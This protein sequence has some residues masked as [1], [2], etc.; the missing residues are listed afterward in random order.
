MPRTVSVTRNRSR[1]G[2]LVISDPRQ[3]L[4][5]IGAHSIVRRGEN[6]RI[7]R[8]FELLQSE[9]VIQ[10]TEIPGADID[11]GGLRES[12]RKLQSFDVHPESGSRGNR[13][14]RI[15]HHEPA[16]RPPIC[17]LISRRHKGPRALSAGVNTVYALLTG[18]HSQPTAKLL[19]ITG[20]S[21]LK[22]W[23]VDYIQQKGHT[24]SIVR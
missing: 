20:A 17:R 6:L 19:P 11:R 23:E 21:M 7:K 8:C 10:Y 15:F 13:G 9:G 2:D 16:I 5:F 3:D 4:R 1:W 18:L 24:K 22:T 14:R 12:L